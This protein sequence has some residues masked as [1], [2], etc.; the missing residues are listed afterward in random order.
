ML[1]IIS[2]FWFFLFYDHFNQELFIYYINMNFNHSKQHYN[3]NDKHD[4]ENIY[5][6]IFFY[7]NVVGPYSVI[8]YLKIK[9]KNFSFVWD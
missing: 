4:D 5:K 9:K 6:K 2:L 3:N 7:I 1:K 8:L